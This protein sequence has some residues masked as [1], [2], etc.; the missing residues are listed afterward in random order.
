MVKQLCAVDVLRYRTSDQRREGKKSEKNEIR[1]EGEKSVMDVSLAFVCLVDELK[2]TFVRLN[3][4]IKYLYEGKAVDRL[5]S[6]S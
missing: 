6:Q 3:G 1:L 2:L 5:R 4:R